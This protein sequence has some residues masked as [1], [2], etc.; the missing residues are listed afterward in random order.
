[1]QLRSQPQLSMW[2]QQTLQE[3]KTSPNMRRQNIVLAHALAHELRY[4]HQS[5][6]PIHFNPCL[7]ISNRSGFSPRQTSS[8]ERAPS[9]ASVSR[10]SSARW[11]GSPFFFKAFNLNIKLAPIKL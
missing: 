4:N 1:M 7:L 2:H 10:S 9:G 5:D 3:G 11:V 8:K 6:V